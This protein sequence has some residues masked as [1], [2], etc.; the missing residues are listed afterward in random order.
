MQLNVRTFGPYPRTWLRHAA[1][2]DVLTLDVNGANGFPCHFFAFL[3][4]ISLS[5]VSLLI[6]FPQFFLL[7]NR[8]LNIHILNMSKPI[9]A[10][11]WEIAPQSQTGSKGLES[12]MKPAANWTSM[13]YFDDS[14]EKPY[15]KEYEGRGLMKDKAVLITGGDSG[16]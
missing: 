12:N 2:H 8:L 3:F 9:T 5:A 14:G 15:L 4:F 11:E 6:P 13:E 7:S 16:T 1:P 10:F